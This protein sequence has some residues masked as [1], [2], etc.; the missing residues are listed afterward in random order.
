MEPHPLASAASQQQ[1]TPHTS[2]VTE[3]HKWLAGDAVLHPR[4]PLPVAR[5]LAVSTDILASLCRS[6]STPAR[7]APAPAA[8]PA[9]AAPAPAPAPAPAAHAQTAPAVQHQAPPPAHYAPQPSAPGLGTQIMANAAS[10]AIV[11]LGFCWKASGCADEGT[12]RAQSSPTAPWLQL[13]RSW[14]DQAH[15]LSKQHRC[16]RLSSSTPK[17][18]CS[19]RMCASLSSSNSSTAHRAI[20]L[21]SLSA[22]SSMTPSSSAASLTTVCY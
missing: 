16:R 12:N 7:A 17:L 11:S 6:S 15:P 20:R 14:A 22:L 4:L 13:D 10:V 3:P 8:A 9:R 5:K 21:T 19:S 2:F 18:L 1:Q